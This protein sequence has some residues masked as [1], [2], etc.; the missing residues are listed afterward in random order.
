MIS[1]QYLSTT[2]KAA[3]IVAVITIVTN[4]SGQSSPMRGLWVG[5]VKLKAVNEVAVPLDAANVPVA[6]NPSVPTPT[7][8]T[9]ELRLIIHVNGAGQA[10]LIKDVAVLNR[11]ASGAGVVEADMA[12]VTD[13]RL[14]PEFPPQPAMRIASA[15]FDFGDA[16]T[17][18]AL[19]AI[20][21]EAAQQA[22]AFTMAISLPLTTPT[23]RNTAIA[24]AV[25]SITPSLHTISANADVALGFDSFLNSFD[26]AALEAIAADTNATILATL[27]T[28]AETLRDQSFFGDTRALD[29]VQAVVRD[30]AATLDST[31]RLAIINNTAS[32][33]ADIENEYQRFIAG[34]VFSDMISACAATA[35]SSA[36]AG[37]TTVSITAD[38]KATQAAAGAYT[39]GLLAKVHRYDDTRST[40]AIDAVLGAIAASAFAN[41]ALPASEIQRL[42]EEAGRT[43]LSEEV[44]RQ[45]LPATAP[46]LDY[47]DFISSSAF[48]GAAQT[49]A[50]AA[51]DAAIRERAGNKLYTQLSVY[52]AAKAAAATA[53]RS[54]YVTAARAKR[55]ELPLS[56][57][58]APGSG[59][60]RL[61]ATLAQ[62]G[63]LGPAGL[64]GTVI[65]PADHPTNPFRHRR[66]P[67]H[68]TG[69]DIRR[70]IR[71]DFDPAPGGA[72]ESAGY[73]VKSI[74]G[75]YREE[76]FGLHK[77][78]G[79]APET[80]PVGLKTEGFFELT[81][82]S[83]IDTLN[84][85]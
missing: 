27:R 81:R 52:G 44:G 4:V 31:E 2:A 71:L 67:D 60:P 10:C 74:T 7:Y 22:T 8:D 5:S 56:G 25:T 41:R 76:I 79:P 14:Y 39:A 62:P 57:T 72:I 47:N 13:P 83:E 21:E 9:A 19:D 48:Q 82:I 33:A 20:T 30:A 37:G 40:D 17:T 24:A 75:T 46:T 16:Q 55:T 73:G 18:S 53:L 59:D 26:S 6:P 51:A 1:R 50:Q 23:E 68:T 32:S 49:A 45:V 12:L 28:A 3:A 38:M 29:M 70:E 34:N 84:A 58:F 63:D 69:F 35:A 15:T 61:T 42:A 11:E 54:T 80:A 65:L 66:H 85:R 43:K 78:L 36:S 77:A 64:T